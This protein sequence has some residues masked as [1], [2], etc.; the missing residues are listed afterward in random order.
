MLTEEDPEVTSSID[1]G[2]L[3]TDRAIHPEEELRA[4]RAASAE[5]MRAGPCRE[6]QNRQRYRNEGS[7][8]F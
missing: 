1:T 5:Q 2:N 6:R 8:R 4:G 7:H 3:P